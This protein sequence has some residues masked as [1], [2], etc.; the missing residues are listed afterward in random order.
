MT[1]NDYT[2]A[3]NSLAEPFA[4]ARKS[5]AN[6]ATGGLTLGVIGFVIMVLGTWT[7]FM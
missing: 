1:P 2:Q 5:I 6:M 4:T 3:L 7:N